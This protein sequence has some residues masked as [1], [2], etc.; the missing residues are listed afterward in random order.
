MAQDLNINV[1]PISRVEGHGDLVIDMKNR[2]IQKMIM[3]IPESPRFFE[4]MLVGRDW[5]QPSHITSRICGICSVAHTFASIK[6]TEDA[7][8]VKINDQILRL[9]KLINH[10]ECVQSNALHVYFL[11]APDFLG[12]GSVIPLLKTHP[13]VVQI[14]VKMKKVANEI[15]RIIGGRAVHPIRTV[16]G[17]FTKIPTE[18]EIYQMREML[19]SLYPDLQKS[20]EVFKTLKMPDFERETEYICI[21]DE[22]EYALYDGKIKSSDGWVIECRDYLDKINEKV[23]QHSTG[24]HCWAT[25]DSYL[26]GALS[27]LNNNYD[28]LTENAKHY[29]E[30]LGIKIPCY[31]TFMNNFAQFVEIVHCVDDSI[32]ILEELLEDGLDENNAMVEVKAREG[33][34][35][36]VV[37]AP[38][39]LLIHDYTYDN[40]GRI[41][42]A[43]LIIPTNMNYANIEKDMEAFLPSII[44]KTEDEIRF[45]MEMLIRAYDP[46]ISCSTHFLKVRLVNK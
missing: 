25:R 22:K 31:N 41:K 17:G 45:D 24:K 30:E 4:A 11:A 46:C 28:K 19:K 10:N 9:R 20:L 8:G 35:V 36:G 6:A 3:G 23:V 1:S 40:N 16:V 34:G 26:V 2:K 29:A 32:K 21:S 37:E 27:R 7:M 18:Q 39:G 44:D 12:V 42:K 5:E 38:R 13:E 43:N 14:A 15:V 33:R